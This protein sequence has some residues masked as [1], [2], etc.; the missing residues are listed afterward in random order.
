[1]YR[2]YADDARQPGS[3]NQHQYFL[4]A[5]RDKQNHGSGSCVTFSR[6]CHIIDEP[7]STANNLANVGINLL[8]CGST[9]APDLRRA[10]RNRVPGVSVSII[11]AGVVGNSSN[12]YNGT[13]NHP[14]VFQGRQGQG[15]NSIVFQGVPFDPPGTTTRFL[16]FTNVRANANGAGIAQANQTS[17]ITMGIASSGNTVLQLSVQSLAVATVLKGLTTSTVTTNLTFAQCNSQIGL[18]T[19]STRP[20]VRPMVSTARSQEYAGNSIRGR[21]QQRLEDKERK[22]HF[23]EW[24]LQREQLG[25]RLYAV[26]ALITP[27][28]TTRTFRV[29][30]NTKAASYRFDSPESAAALRDLRHWATA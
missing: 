10:A 7:N 9:N 8:N 28:I 18:L 27:V 14:N 17:L 25:R 20:L 16:R 26:N 22:L 1:M 6:R 19:A 2:R 12:T 11:S 29:S 15:S 30:Y 23:D 21:V 13:P 5:E 3:G 4:V 24:H